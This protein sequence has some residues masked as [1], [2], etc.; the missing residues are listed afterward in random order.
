MNAEELKK[1]DMK[2]ARRYDNFRIAFTSLLKNNEDY[3]YKGKYE[4]VSIRTNLCAIGTTR[5][6][7]ELVNFGVASHIWQA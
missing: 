4:K 3:N 2:P 7:I 6:G 5:R 1:N